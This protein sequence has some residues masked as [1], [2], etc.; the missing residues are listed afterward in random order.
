M[1]TMVKFFVQFGVKIQSK[2]FIALSGL[3]FICYAVSSNEMQSAVK[4]FS[5]V[6]KE[7]RPTN[8]TTLGNEYYSTVD[9][10]K[11]CSFILWVPVCTKIERRTK[12]FG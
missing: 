3:N 9:L 11:T 7:L 10:K 6:H 2:L 12:I 1:D 8:K 5:L 4:I